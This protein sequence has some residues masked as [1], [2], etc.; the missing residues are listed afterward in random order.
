MTYAN[1]PMLKR[2]VWIW[3]VPVYFYI[4][5]VAGA[6]LVF[7]AA[8]QAVDR[9]G[10]DGLIRKC[11]WIAAAGQGIG[12][13]LLIIDLGRPERFLNMFRTFQP[14][15]ALSVGS[16]VLAIGGTLS[17]ASIVLPKRAADIAGYAAGVMGIPL[18]GYTGVLLGSTAIP[19]W[20]KSRTALPVLSMAAGVTGFVSL[21]EM[22]NLPHHQLRAVRRF[23]IL[24]KAAEVAA[25]SAVKRPEA[26]LPNALWKAAGVLTVGSLAMSL[27]SDNSKLKRAAGIAGTLGA[28]GLRFAVFYAG[29]SAEA[30][31]ARISHSES[32]SP[33]NRY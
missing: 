3:S 17:G 1:Q 10:F 20:Q 23:G 13:A 28:I 5:G 31:L 18:A 2:P 33:S 14:S 30:R 6:A 12:A 11:R 8:A 27:L 21:F 15:S 29:F 26:G 32:Q 19:V 9:K 7:G 4:G 16:W 22:M 24:G 25:M